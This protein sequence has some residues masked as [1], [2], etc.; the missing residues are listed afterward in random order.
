MLIEAALV[1]GGLVV[2][3]QSLAYGAVDDRYRLAVGLRGG[4]C[5]AGVDGG[6]DLLDRGAQFRALT[7]IALAV[8]FRLTR[9]LGCLCCI[10]QSTTPDAGGSKAAYYAD[11][12]VICQSHAGGRMMARASETSEPGIIASARTTPETIP[13][14]A[15]V[16]RYAAHRTEPGIVGPNR[17]AGRDLLLS[18]CFPNGLYI[19]SSN[20]PAMTTQPDAPRLWR[21]RV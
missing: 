18:Y 20:P 7:G 10:G 4:L 17:C 12:R 8:D 9:A 21:H 14:A 19:R 13:G 11:F 16:D 6:K 2:M 1:A 15:M 3:N 5:I